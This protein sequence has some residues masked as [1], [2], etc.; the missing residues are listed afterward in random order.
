LLESVTAAYLEGL[1]EREFDVPFMTLLR[2]GGFYDIHLLHGQYE[3][4]KDFIAKRNDDG[5]QCQYAFQTKAG[6]L[7]AR[8]WAEIRPQVDELRVS[9]LGHPDFDE[10]LPR[11]ARLVTTGRLKG[12]TALLVQEYSQ[13]CGKRNE[14]TLEVWDHERLVEKILGHGAVAGLL[15]PRTGLMALVAA[16]EKDEVAV[17]DL[18][19]YTRSWVA[20]LADGWAP[21]LEASL[22][23]H[24]LR[25][26]KRSNLSV[27]VTLALFRAAESSRLGGTDSAPVDLADA[28]AGDMFVTYSDLVLEELGPLLDAADGLLSLHAQSSSAPL[29]HTVRC[30]VITEILALRGL[31]ALLHSEAEV[32]HDVAS[33]LAGV[34]RQYPACAHPLSD[35]YACTVQ[36]VCCLLAGCGHPEALPPYLREVVKWVCDAHERG[37][38]LAGVHANERR[39]VDQL[40]GYAL[41]HVKTERRRASYLATTLLDL[42]ALTGE[43]G[44]FNAGKQVAVG[45][46][47][48]RYVPGESPKGGRP[49]NH[50]GDR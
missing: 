8:G 33:R 46:R 12:K 11:K 21:F 34:L 19:T 27:A 37:D 42:L 31:Y 36:V 10:S 20:D 18:E 9:A 3:F 4:G 22:L 7:T 47:R 6:D 16:V 5:E 14:P 32:A 17:A 24:R 38:G 44:L 45:N 48:H 30:C 15:G 23:A 28:L 29:S 49:A 26:R 35:R 40:L 41:E 25:E 13:E 2:H 1:T 39:E 43:R 50:A